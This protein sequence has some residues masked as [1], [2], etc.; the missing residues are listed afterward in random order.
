MANVKRPKRGSLCN[1]RGF[2]L[3]LWIMM[4]TRSSHSAASKARLFHKLKRIRVKTREDKMR[5]SNFAALTALAIAW[6][7]GCGADIT[8]GGQYIG[9]TCYSGS[10]CATGLVCRDRICVATTG[11]LGATDMTQPDLDPGVDMDRP[12][13]PPRVDMTQGCQV[14]ERACLSDRVFTQCDATPDGSILRTRTCPD[15]TTC[16]NGRCINSCTDADNDGFF[17]NCEPFDCDDTTARVNPGRREGCNDGIDNNCNMQIDEGCQM[18]C[19]E[20]GCPNDSFCNQCV[21]QP[22]D[23]NVCTAQD[24]PCVNEG[25]FDNGF[26]CAD[27][28]EN[29]ELRCVGICQ[30]GG[31]NPDATCPQ[32]NTVCAIN[33]DQAQG[34]CL[35]GCSLNQGC[36]DSSLGCLPFDNSSTDGICVPAR[37][38]APIGSPCNVNDTFS[39][40]AGAICLESTTQPGGAGVCTQACRPFR[41]INGASDCDLGRHCQPLSPQVGFCVRDNGLKEGET[42]RNF[43]TACGDDSV[44]CF[45]TADGRQRCQR[46]CRLDQ[47]AND[48]PSP[49]TRCRQFSQDQDGIGVCSR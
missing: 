33:T 27:V 38:G 46:L 5:A 20:G 13:Q 22:F 40:A 10:D 26:A 43:N 39:C 19:C 42:C 4:R 49:M 3:E 18:G 37:A 36:G 35:A 21:C 17:A 24:Q 7:S 41:F 14:G 30:Q 31:I 8:P 32:P 48:C 9:Q 45:P 15:Q 1:H 28:F 11:I 25:S 23:P 44:G 34:L 6:L 47:G 29:G 16:E 2:Q 12:D